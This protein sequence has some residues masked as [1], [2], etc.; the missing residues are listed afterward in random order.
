MR[1]CTSTPSIGVRN[2]LVSTSPAIPLLR[3][4]FIMCVSMKFLSSLQ[5]RSMSVFLGHPKA[6]KILDIR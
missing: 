4:P 2:F 3:K 6:K 1:K 5:L